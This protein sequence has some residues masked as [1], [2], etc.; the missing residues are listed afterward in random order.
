MSATTMATFADSL[1]RVCVTNVTDSSFDSLIP[2][3]TEPTTAL[4]DGVIELGNSDIVSN[5]LLLLF[6]GAGADDSTFSA[7]LV[8]WKPAIATPTATGT[9]LWVPVP[10]CQ[11]NVILSTAVGV[12][13]AVV[14]N[15]DRFAD[16]IT[17][18]MG[19]ELT[20]VTVISPAT[21]TAAVANV[22]ASALVD[23]KGFRKFQMIFDMTG[24]TNGNALYAVL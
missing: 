20:D 19:N 22:I 7:R 18:T 4:I 12:A 11:F 10:L 23:M 1:R 2:T 14:I 3:T 13:D 5:N 24:A 9:T 17:V 21:S 15:T 16:T 6:F 8:G